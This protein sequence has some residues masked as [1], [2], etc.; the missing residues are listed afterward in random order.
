M[1]GSLFERARAGMAVET[2]AVIVGVVETDRCCGGSDVLHIN[3]AQASQ[4]RFEVAVEH[5][6][7]MAGV[8]SLVRR[9]AM[10]LK[11]SSRQVARVIDVEA[12]PVRIHDV[13]GKT[14]L[15]PLRALHVFRSPHRH[16]E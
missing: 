8:A 14:E 13:A 5:V 2:L 11:M 15:C 7:R 16:T 3:M 6:V 1:R 9:D 4:L 10:M 12:F